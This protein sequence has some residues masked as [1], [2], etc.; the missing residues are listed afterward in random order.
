MFVV[1]G[2]IQ[3]SSM[4]T[5]S[6]RDDT[7]TVEATLEGEASTAEHMLA[8]LQ[9]LDVFEGM[10]TASLRDNQIGKIVSRVTNASQWGRTGWGL[11]Q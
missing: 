4:T 9:A 6:D 3:L 7:A 10:V 2:C 8:V 5:A 11:T 1:Q